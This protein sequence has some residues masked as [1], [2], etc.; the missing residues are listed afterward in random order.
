ML[1]KLIKG[2]A[3]EQLQKVAE[4]TLSGFGAGQQTT[5]WLD[6]LMPTLQSLTPK[7]QALLRTFLEAMK[8]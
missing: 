3:T 1:S 2:L 7:E 5:A 6:E 8:M 4:N